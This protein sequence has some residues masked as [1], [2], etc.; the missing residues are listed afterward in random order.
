MTE[1]QPT[2]IELT[3]KKKKP[4]SISRRKML[5]FILILVLIAIASVLTAILARQASKAP[6]TIQ[7][8]TLPAE[9]TEIEQ[10]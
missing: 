10:P 8:Q 5:V 9:G 3:G 2:E 4:V 1:L 6:D 7:Q